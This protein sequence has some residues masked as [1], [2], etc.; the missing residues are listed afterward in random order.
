MYKRQVLRAT[1]PGL[2]AVQSASFV[3]TP[4]GPHHLAVRTQP[5]TSTAAGDPVSVTIEL[6][7]PFNNVATNAG[8]RTVGVA[9]TTGAGSLLSG[10]TSKAT[11]AGVATFSGLQIGPQ[12]SDKVITATSV[13]LVSTATAAFAITPAA[14]A[15]LQMKTQPPAS[16]VAGS[17]FS[18]AVEVRDAYGNVQVSMPVT[19]SAALATGVSTLSGGGGATSAAG[20]ASQSGLS[21]DRVGAHTVTVSSPG[22]SSV[23]TQSVT[24]TAAAGSALVFETQPASSAVAGQS[25]TYAAKV[26]DAFGNHAVSFGGPVTATLS[27]G[28]GAL[29]G[30][31]TV[32]ASDGSV[33]F[34]ATNIQAAGTGKQVTVSAESLS[35]AAS[36]L[37][38]VVHGAATQLS[39]IHI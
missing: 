32:S 17:A 13:G 27:A 6:R 7:D 3:I 21:L 33:T 29:V 16:V 34:G 39:L 2:P 23:T 11:S 5:A 15:V 30:T 25:F 20:V 8:A 37:F 31:T 38:E 28:S 26:L 35:S 4:A 9:L 36:T 1:A 18:L 22:L 14:P 24:V 12:G 10:S 19:V